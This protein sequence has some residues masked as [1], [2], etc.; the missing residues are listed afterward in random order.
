MN[1]K[2]LFK[3]KEN[4][5]TLIALVIT[6]IVLLI[7]AGVAISMLSGENGILKRA[8]EA[9]EE[10]RFAQIEEIIKLWKTENE[11]YTIIGE[12]T[13]QNL[14]QVLNDLESENLIT[15]EERNQIEN[16]GV[17][18]IGEKIILFKNIEEIVKIGDYVNYNPEEP[19][20]D[21]ISHLENNI[22]TY[23]GYSTTQEVSQENLKWRILNIN[24]NGTINLISASTTKDTP[25]WLKGSLGYNNGVYLLNE[26]CNVLYSNSEKGAIARSINIE[27]IQKKI[28]TNVW[29][30]HDYIS[31]S[32]TKYGEISSFTG[33]KYPYMWSQ[34]KTTK[35][36]INDELINGTLGQSEQN[37]L[38]SD[39]YLTSSSSIEAEING[40]AMSRDTARSAFKK[41]N[42]NS[43]INMEMLWPYSSRVCWIASRATSDFS[44]RPSRL[45]FG[46]FKLDHD[47]ANGYISVQELYNPEWGNQFPSY[48]H[49]VRPIVT[50]STDILNIT[51]GNG[52]SDSP[53]GI[54]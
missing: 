29:N 6:I 23:S 43:N 42:N 17:L 13:V 51:E 8:G 9:K 26:Y 10:T 52:T 20:E 41:E 18:V 46:L 32:G 40:W 37:N 31:S 33:T 14:D 21:A 34:E 28:D 25:L 2:N 47:Y 38:V 1:Q 49:Y 53:W 22:N 19:T 5:I 39:T 11:I 44:I 30:Y 24:D 50:I 12:D 3:G 16:T 36:K 48:E 27:D 4:G 35:S 15:S 54:K 7:L 45:S